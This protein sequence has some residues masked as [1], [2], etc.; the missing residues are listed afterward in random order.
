MTRFDGAFA[1]IAVATR[2][3]FDE[4]LYHGAGVALAAD[5]SLIAH[6]GD[7]RLVVYPR[8]CLKPM[9]AHA[10]VGLG[11]ELPDELLAVACASHAGTPMHLDAVRAIL[12]R[13]GLDVSQLQNT[14]APALS[15]PRSQP[16]SLRQNCSGKHAAMLATCVV[17]AWPTET[18]LDV[19][20]PLQ[21]AIVAAFGDLGCVVH[22]IGVDGCGAPTHALALDEL[23]GAF[24]RLASTDA[25]AARSMRATPLMV[26]GAEFDDTLWMRAVP[27]LMAKE[28]AAGMMAMALAD[29]RA[30]AFKIADGSGLARQAVIPEALRVLGVDVDAA[31]PSARERAVV[32]VLG[33]GR[34][35]G[36]IVPLEWTP[37]SS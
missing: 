32:P 8:S 11:L 17:N 14:A 28:G 9:Q 12:A 5:G 4:S 3:G 22:H 19:E 37:W 30:A 23:A 24:A 31:A 18:Y 15:D 33:H 1:P 27:G 13:Y 34:E 20:H 2:S 25:P 35:V 16:S 7:P 36:R 26:G 10:M 29:G 21:L 6:V